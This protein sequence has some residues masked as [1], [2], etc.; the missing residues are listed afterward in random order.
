MQ[1][2]KSLVSLVCHFPK[3][4]NVRRKQQQKTFY[5]PQ[6]L[7]AELKPKERA[8]PTEKANAPATY[9]TSL[10]WSAD[11][12]TLYSGYTDGTIRAWGVSDL[13]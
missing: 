8:V 3:T 13:G 10:A 6:V 5:S 1:E 4:S 11:G 2:K 12:R 7:V 9:A